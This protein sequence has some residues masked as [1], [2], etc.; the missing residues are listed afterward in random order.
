MAT[1]ASWPALVD[2]LQ[3]EP[4]TREAARAAQTG[5]AAAALWDENRKAWGTLN[6][7]LSALALADDARSPHNVIITSCGALKTLQRPSQLDLTF[8][9]PSLSST[10]GGIVVPSEVGDLLIFMAWCDDFAR[11]TRARYADAVMTALAAAGYAA[12]GNQAAGRITRKFVDALVPAGSTWSDVNSRAIALRA[13]LAAVPS[14]LAWVAYI[15]RS[16][17]FIALSR[18]P[19]S[20]L[21]KLFAFGKARPEVFY[22]PVDDV[23][24]TMTAAC[25]VAAGVEF[26]AADSR[27]TLSGDILSALFKCIFCRAPLVA[28][29]AAG[30]GG[31]GGEGGAAAAVAAMARRAGSTSTRLAGS[32]ALGCGGSFKVVVPAA[33]CGAWA[34]LTVTPCTVDHTS[35]LHSQTHLDL[36]PLVRRCIVE[37]YQGHDKKSDSFE[38]IREWAKTVHAV[39]C[40][41]SALILAGNEPNVPY[42]MY[43]STATVSYAAVRALPAPGKFGTVDSAPAGQSAAPVT[44]SASKTLCVCKKKVIE[45]SGDDLIVCA[46]V[47]CDVMQF[48]RV[49]VN[50][51]PDVLGARYFGEDSDSDADEAGGDAVLSVRWRCDACKHSTPIQCVCEGKKGS[52]DADSVECSF[53][54]SDDCVEWYH[55]ACVGLDEAPAGDWACPAC[56]LALEEAGG[57]A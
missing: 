33:D 51:G 41:N 11:H 45:S 47:R 8:P 53:N 32:V 3:R 43:K 29:D 56:V 7:R 38:S 52:L 57:D 39:E 40:A 26:A 18:P 21:E 19:A 31:G 12:G 14:S 17:S 20:L 27:V 4:P 1:L 37:L 34:I 49:C 2:L 9:F 28:V 10:H 15:E 30:G 50:V 5:S 55:L 13:R 46:D 54:A 25:V 44:A 22:L 42:P 48:H 16:K 36:H 23:M 35:E 24:Q 6:P